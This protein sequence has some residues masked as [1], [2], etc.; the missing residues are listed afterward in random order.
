MSGAANK[1]RGLCRRCLKPLVAVGAAR[2]GGKA[3]ADW[4]SRE[5]HKKCFIEE[6]REQPANLYGS[7][8]DSWARKRPRSDASHAPSSQ[9]TK[10]SY[11]DELD[12]QYEAEVQRAKYQSDA[13]RCPQCRMTA[14]AIRS[15]SRANL[16]R[17]FF[18][19]KMASCDKSFLMWCD[20]G[21]RSRSGSGSGSSGNSSGSSA[22]Q[23]PPSPS[24]PPHAAAAAAA[25]PSPRTAHSSSCSSRSTPYERLLDA[26]QEGDTAALHACLNDDLSTLKPLLDLAGLARGGTTP[27]TALRYAA[28][29]GFE[30]CVRALL[31][32]G[33]LPN[34]RDE[35]QN[36][37]ALALA[38]KGVGNRSARGPPGERVGT[39]AALVA[40]SRADVWEIHGVENRPEVNGRHVRI[41]HLDVYAGKATIE[42]AQQSDGSADDRQLRLK[43]AKLR[44]KAMQ[45]GERGTL[46]GLSTSKFNGCAVTVTQPLNDKE[47]YSVQF[48]ATWGR[49]A[50]VAEGTEIRVKRENLVAEW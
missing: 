17:F 16:G 39:I 24:A 40:A 34:L 33:A 5:L 1:P 7:P 44:R 41:I 20:S 21:S 47:R 32:A 14:A 42:D 25:A 15:K 43:R 2:Q 8:L 23:P 18:L 45:K 28:F 30:G 37:D 31:N 13:P 11:Q 6:Q 27:A 50:D 26:A 36:N 3:H 46:I 48:D 10:S 35:F 29:H 12:R 22:A 4:E 38:R 19:C 49:K 9:H